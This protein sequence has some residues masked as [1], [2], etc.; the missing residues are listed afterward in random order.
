MA[1]IP[2]S[3]DEILKELKDDH[4]SKATKY[5]PRLCYSL[6]NEDQHL[7]KEDITERIKKDLIDIWS[8][9][10]IYDNIP[11]EFKHEV[12]QKAGRQ[13]HKNVADKSATLTGPEIKEPIQVSASGQSISEPQNQNPDPNPNELTPEQVEQMRRD[14]FDNEPLPKIT[15]TNTI[16]PITNQE[17][18]TM[19]S[20]LKRTDDE[21]MKRLK[22]IKDQ[23]SKIFNLEQQI[24][25][26]IER[27]PD[28][29]EKVT[30]AIRKF[31]LD[32]EY[33]PKKLQNADC[34]VF[35]NTIILD[36][37]AADWI[38][39]TLKKDLA[40]LTKTYFLIQQD[41]DEP[42]SLRINHLRTDFK[43]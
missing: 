30:G 24:K 10:T 37:A 29:N 25:T 12:K 5:I 31:G 39:K 35:D 32:Y 41:F 34:R 33:N 4:K 2:D 22:E 36:V 19:R 20:K 7:S 14:A 16:A 18:E 1:I 43:T 26:M 3:Y 42:K 15:A 17:V 40:V 8:R 13:S 6:Q 21:L 11:D 23:D 27:K 38:A 9:T 28:R